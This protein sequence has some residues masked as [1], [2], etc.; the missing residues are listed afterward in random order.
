MDIV[1]VKE[2]EEQDSMELDEDSIIVDMGEELRKEKQKQEEEE[3]K[4]K[5]KRE[6][7]EKKRQERKEKKRQERKEREEKQQEVESSPESM[8]ARY[9]KFT[10]KARIIFS[11]LHFI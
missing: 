1:P 9:P 3:R 5:E 4:E 2:E 7:K 8:K 11:F 6:L 10:P